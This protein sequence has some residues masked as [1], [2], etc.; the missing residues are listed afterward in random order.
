MI[1]SGWRGD[2]FATVLWDEPT[3]HT[4]VRT[5]FVIYFHL[6]Q[7]KFVHL[8]RIV[9]ISSWNR[10]QLYCNFNGKSLGKCKVGELPGEDAVALCPPFPTI[11]MPPVV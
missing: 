3:V 1:A 2:G 5:K 6:V 4:R 7:R 8:C 11:R 9:R 10:K